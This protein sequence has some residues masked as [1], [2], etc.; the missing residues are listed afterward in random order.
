MQVKAIYEDGAINFTQPLQFKRRKFEVI[1][2]IP[3]DE[4]ES[5]ETKATALWAPENATDDSQER[6]SSLETLLAQTP[7]DPWLK[8]MKAIELRV[9]SLPD[10]QIPDLTAKQ[11]DRIEA[12]A[13]RGDR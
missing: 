3:E 7:N 13:L 9:L 5:G 12:F 4:L 11:L 6:P 2:N 8:R 1:V 10:D